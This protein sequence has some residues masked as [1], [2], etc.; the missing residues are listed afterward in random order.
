MQELRRQLLH[1]THL[2]YQKGWVANHD[3]NLT[4]RSAPDRLLATP[5]AMSKADIED[6]D[7]ITVDGA[8]QKV[9]GQRKPF[10]ELVLHLA[11]YKQRPDVKAVIH[12]HPPYASAMSVA[13][14]G[15][16]RAFIAEAVVSLGER[17]PLVPFAPPKTP[18]FAGGVAEHCVLYDALLLQNHGVIAYGESLEQA[19]LRLEL[20]EHLATILHH[21]MAFGGPRYLDEVHLAP[22][23]EARTQAGLGPIAR[24]VK[25]A[26]KAAA[27]THIPAPAPAVRVQP[28]RDQLV[29]IITDELRKLSSS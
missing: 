7:L 29:A 9:S 20:V 21:S 5:T 2:I 23:L 22:L 3:G 10:S 14:V 13:G 18:G 16:D 12:A 17:V 26:P 11:V 4:A 8:G 6:G 24:G 1:Y 25:A 19:F 15:L 27:P 28:S